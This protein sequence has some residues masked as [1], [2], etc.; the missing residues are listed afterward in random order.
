M[1]MRRVRPT[2]PLIVS[3]GLIEEPRQGGM[4]REIRRPELCKQCSAPCIAILAAWWSLSSS[5]M[6]I[7]LKKFHAE[8]LKFIIVQLFISVCDR[9]WNNVGQFHNITCTQ[10]KAKPKAQEGANWRRRG[11]CAHNWR[12]R[13][14]VLMCLL[15]HSSLFNS[16]CGVCKRVGDKGW[17]GQG[18]D[19]KTYPQCEFKETDQR[20]GQQRIDSEFGCQ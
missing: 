10:R 13:I 9:S 11:D 14:I 12:F 8:C 16:I 17:R 15:Y 3:R 7:E 4:H 20:R 2:I 18:M 5:L 6:W 19:G 1:I